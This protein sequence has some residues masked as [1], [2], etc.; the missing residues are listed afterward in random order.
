MQP[1]TRSDRLPGT[2]DTVALRWSLACVWLATG[3]LV[4]SHAYQT[5]GISWLNRLGLPSWL[6]FATCV[7]EVGLGV[8]LLVRPTGS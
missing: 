2:A 1:S 5:I 4:V 7:A 3:L 6:M 8:W